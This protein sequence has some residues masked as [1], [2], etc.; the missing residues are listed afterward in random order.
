MDTHCHSSA[1]S[2]PAVKALGYIGCPECYSH[3][4]Q[5]YAQ[6][7]SRGMDLVTITDHD[8]IDGAQY[9]VNH[10]YPGVVIGEEVTVHFPEDRCKLHVLVWCLNADLHEQIEALGLRRDVYQFAAWLHENNLPHSLAHPLYEQNHRLTPWHIDR[11][12]LLFKGFEVL[13]GAHAGTH[14]RALDAYLASFNAGKAHRL[15]QQHSLEPAWN[16]IWEK[17]ATG[18]SDDH[19]LLNIGRTWTGVSPEDAREMGVPA[20]CVD[21]QG[22][23]TCPREFFR[24]VMAG[25]AIA[26]GDSGHSALLAHQLTTVAAHYYADR[27]ADKSTPTGR[28]VASKMLR[29]A[30]ARVTPPAKVRLAAHA[31]IRKVRRRRSRLHPVLDALRLGYG[32]VMR[33]YPDLAQRLDPSA[34]SD[35]A[36]IA[37]HDRMAA[38][39]DDLYEAMHRVMGSSALKAL[40]AKDH[41]LLMDHL[42]SYAVLELSQLP[43]LFS[44]FHQNKERRLVEHVE[45]EAATPGDG[46]SVLERPMRVMLF[47]DTLG[48]VNGVSRF[49]RNAASQALATG[50][51]LRVVTSTNF[52]IPEQANIIN[53]APVLATKMPKYEN[54]E[55]VLP[56]LVR[57]LRL[58]DKV[59]P[60]VV[61]IS[62]PGPVGLVGL[63]AAKMLRVPI[64][65]VY[66]TDFPA[67]IEKLFR[68]DSLTHGCSQFMKMF[69]S[70]FATI[71]TRSNDYARSLAGMGLDAS[72]LEALM[73]GIMTEEFH[74]RYRDERVA[75]EAGLTPGAVRVLYVGRVSVEKNLPLL[76]RVWSRAGEQ[77]L[78]MGVDA[79]LV[80]IGDGPYRAEM[81]RELRGQRARFLGFRHGR[82][83]SS[84]YAASDLFAFPSTTD[85]LGQV[86]ME[87][88][89]SG[90]PVIVTD[91]GGPREVVDDGATGFVIPA[92]DEAGWVDRI[93]DLA[94]NRDK[95]RRMGQA[96]HEAMQPFSMARSFEHYWQVHERVWV[97]HLAKHNIKSKGPEQDGRGVVE[98][99]PL[100]GASRFSGAA[101]NRVPGYEHAAD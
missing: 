2:G 55:L 30:G 1:S 94:S 28:F 37:Q 27:L 6:A 42:A 79:E 45:H 58:A 97:Q 70:Q 101:R 60:D 75:T 91:Q 26:G 46:V 76:T 43:T 23:I 81:E 53:V 10:H 29:F 12:A 78:R 4:E 31:L 22:K 85:T 34:W 87:S 77:L 9:L 71:F 56:P 84:L 69:Y 61:H 13:N 96:A 95:C 33:D 72:R 41:R 32:E 74:P 86:V 64:V 63:I 44:L 68:D 93:V 19:G 54:L 82:E 48:D 90:L 100:P 17:A 99:L 39:T 49:I 40:R 3:P 15:I 65:G 38:L 14:R 11:C 51:D 25:R 62:T 47:T 59:Q 67:Y 98:T 92:H 7:K 66:H 18:G 35:G 8:T 73:P 36:A 88:Q 89:S 16:R 21:V 5:V 50:R 20:S 83:L 57:M 52:K 24:V 80:V